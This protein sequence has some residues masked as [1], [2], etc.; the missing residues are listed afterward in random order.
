M[1]L[2][3][4]IDMLDVVTSQKA[5]FGYILLRRINWIL[6]KLL[7]FCLIFRARSFELIWNFLPE[8]LKFY[9]L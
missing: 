2:K 8:N 1:N 3:N 7:S 6:W 4:D 5:V 9:Q